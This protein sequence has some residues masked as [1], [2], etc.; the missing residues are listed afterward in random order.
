M[1]VAFSRQSLKPE[2][3]CVSAESPEHCMQQIQVLLWAG[4][5]HLV[6]PHLSRLCGQGWIGSYGKLTE[7]GRRKDHSW[8]RTDLR[9]KKVPSP[10]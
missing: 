8:L 2:I 1:A 5:G 7:E 9:S 3:Q 6:Y 10:F 4:E